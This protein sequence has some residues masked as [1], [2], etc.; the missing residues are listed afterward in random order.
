VKN[1]K[2]DSQLDSSQICGACHEDTFEQWEQQRKL[3]EYPTCHGC[4]GVAV[5]RPHT[6]GTNFFSKFLVSFEPEH[7]VR[8]H[9]IRLPDSTESGIGPDVLLDRIEGNT[10]HFLLIN[11]LPHDLPTGSFA[12]KDLF[13]QFKWQGDD[14]PAKQNKIGINRVLAPGEQYLFTLPYPNEVA[15]RQLQLELFRDDGTSENSQLIHSYLFL[16]H[17]TSL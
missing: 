12:E 15:G 7:S 17:S 5:K 6:K 3:Q 13:L 2:V 16:L 14:K 8:S 1:S 4:H 11:S 9:Y 10:I